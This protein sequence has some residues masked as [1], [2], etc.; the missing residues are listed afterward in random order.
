MSTQKEYKTR[1]R[2][3]ILSYLMQNKDQHM[4]AEDLVQYLK[5]QGTSVGKSTVYRYLY[6][7][8][9]EGVVRKYASADGQSACYEYC[10][11]EEAC[12]Q[13]YHLKCSGCGELIHLQ[14]E[15][16]DQLSKHLNDNHH[17]Q[18]DQ[19]QTILYGKCQKCSHK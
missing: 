11:N 15:Y 16:F 2:N 7:L 19:T 8:Q 9:K 5:Q 12:H 1:Q 18:I 4:T 10:G 13:H 6:K 3:I 17:F 14:C